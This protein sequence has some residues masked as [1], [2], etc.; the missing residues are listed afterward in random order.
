M[1]SDT[2]KKIII[3]VLVIVVILLLVSCTSP[4]VKE[5]VVTRNEPNPEI[6]FSDVLVN[7][8]K[9]NTIIEDEKTL[10]FTTVLK[11]KGEN[12]V[13]E[14]KVSNN[15]KKLKTKISVTCSES[16]DYLKINNEFD[17]TKELEPGEVREGTLTVTLKKVTFEEQEQKVK[18]TIEQTEI[19]K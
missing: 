12:H 18:C 2:K 4:I 14:Y 15:S 17:A 7:G 5:Y 3:I 11:D 9:D 10:N 16:N 13:L 6:I 8:I 19:E 1:K